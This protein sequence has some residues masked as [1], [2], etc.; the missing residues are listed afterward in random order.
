MLLQGGGIEPSTLFPEA[1]RIWLELRTFRSQNP[2]RK[3]QYISPRTIADYKSYLKQL[4]RFF[5]RLRLDQIH[6][7]HLRQYQEQRSATVGANKINQE[8]GCLQ[9]IMKRAG[10]WT[11]T[12][13]DYYQPL[14]HESP[15]IPRAMTPDE[16]ATLLEIG[17][18]RSEWR[19]TYLYAIVALS[20]TCSNCE[21]RGLKL[22]DLNLTE[23]IMYV[24]NER[25][26]NKHR[27]RTIPIESELCF[28]AL[29]EL[30]QIAAEKGAKDPFHYLF[31]IASS[32]G[33]YNPTKPMTNSGIKKPW[34]S[35]RE[36]A[37]L[38][39][40]RIH[41]LRHSAITR[42]AEAGVPMLVIMSIA[43]HVS[44][45]MLQHY[46]TISEMSKRQALRAAMPVQS[47][48]KIQPAPKKNPAFDLVNMRVGTKKLM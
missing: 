9:Q 38:K 36:A 42:L 8:I 41:D 44:Q 3:T 16:Q 32:R 37:G 27:V 10:M 45:R 31:P 11:A 24:R 6:L 18:T 14:N 33:E 7:G 5:E 47:Q 12:F 39:W 4:D 30:V 28:W 48:L 25:A 1:G 21:M 26:K 35:L 34:E 29:Q 15:D 23:H 13:D 40:V 19:L 17:S 46:T 20:T 22:G 43:G 2:T